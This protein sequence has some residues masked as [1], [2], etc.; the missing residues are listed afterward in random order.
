MAEKRSVQPDVRLDVES[1]KRKHGPKRGMRHADRFRKRHVGIEGL[2]EP[3]GRAADAR[4]RLAEVDAAHRV[5]KQSRVE[6]IGRYVPGDG[7]RAERRGGGG[8]GKGGSVGGDRKLDQLPV[9]AEGL[10]VH[11]SQ[12]S[13]LGS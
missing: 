1:V 12:G 10:F 13:M 9:S 8:F 5:G 11:F 3:P 2:P 6:E 7:R 4:V